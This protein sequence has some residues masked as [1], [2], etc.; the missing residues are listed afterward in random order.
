MRKAG[1]ALHRKLM[2]KTE[3]QATLFGS[4]VHAA[5]EV[6]YSAP[7]S[8]RIIP[9]NMEKNLELM[10]YGAEVPD[11]TR[12][13][14]FCATEA[15][16]SRASALSHLDA[17]DKRSLHNGVWILGEYFRTFIDDPYVVYRDETGAPMVEKYLELEIYDSPTLNIQIHGQIDVILQNLANGQI[18]VCDHK[19][20]SQ[21]GMDFY[22]RLKPNH[23]Y[24]GYLYLAQQCLGLNTEQ[25]LVNC[26][27]VKPK[28]KTTRGQGPHFPRQITVRTKE[29][30]EE[31][32]AAVIFYVTSYLQ[33]L[34][35]GFFPIGSVDSCAM[36]GGCQYLKVCSSPNMIKENIISMEYNIAEDN[37]C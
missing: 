30:I 15:F 36:W 9:P 35:S 12:Y 23:Q 11:Q 31:Y 8:E 33:C 32:K 2:S 28:P 24:T 17:Q 16:I 1:Y 37:I 26:L 10:A 21:V 13:L 6:F 27:Q 14:I 4:A 25:I 19:T 29:D 20:S 18:L 3:S 22:N 7:R 34:E 5:L